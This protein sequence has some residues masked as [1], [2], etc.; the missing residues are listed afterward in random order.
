MKTLIVILLTLVIALNILL[1]A[2]VEWLVRDSWLLPKD[3]TIN[4]GNCAWASLPAAI[5]Q[6]LSE[7]Y[8]F[9]KVND[10]DLRQMIAY[11]TDLLEDYDGPVSL[12]VE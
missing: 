4:L 9:I 2:K 11:Y 1:A 7:R 8:A 3:T 6:D 5:R 12:K 10:N